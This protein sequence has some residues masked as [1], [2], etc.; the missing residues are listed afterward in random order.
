MRT[1]LS[2]YALLVVVVAVA[3]SGCDT[4]KEIGNAPPP[5]VPPTPSEIARTVLDEAKMSGPLPAKGTRLSKNERKATL[6]VLRRAHTKYSAIP[7]PETT[8]DPHFNEDVLNILDSTVDIRMDTARKAKRWKHVLLYADA[9]LIF[10]PNSDR[11]KVPRE[12]AEVELSKPEVSIRALFED[13]N[14]QVAI[15][16]FHIPLTDETFKS[17]ELEMGDALHGMRFLEVIGLDRGVRML[18]EESKEIVNVYFP[19]SL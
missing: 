18:N 14:I 3:S 12:M 11:Y 13:D 4:I 17:L 15:L 1:N 19:R 9:H 16:D 7:D 8:K 10:H 2:I 5:E 6:A